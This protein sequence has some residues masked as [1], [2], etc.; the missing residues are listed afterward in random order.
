MGA[1][2]FELKRDGNIDTTL[3]ETCTMASVCPYDAQQKGGLRLPFQQ[4]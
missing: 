1:F 2:F 3:V 4:L